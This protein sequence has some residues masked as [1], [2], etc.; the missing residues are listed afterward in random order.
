MGT[1]RSTD[2]HATASTAPDAQRAFGEMLRAVESPGALTDKAKELIVFA[3]VVHSRCASCFDAHHDKA[4]GMGITQ[5]EMDEAA[6]CAIAMGGAPVSMF[7]KEA[8][9]RVQSRG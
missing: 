6:W 8:M 9:I 3:L 2:E 1:T 7:Y 5:A 4:L